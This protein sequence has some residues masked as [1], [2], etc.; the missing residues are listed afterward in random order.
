[1]VEKKKKIYRLLLSTLFGM[2]KTFGF[3]F[4][5]ISISKRFY[6]EVCGRV[7]KEIRIWI[8]HVKHQ[9]ITLTEKI[10]GHN[11]FLHP[12]TQTYHLIRLYQGYWC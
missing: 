11:M 6:R 12:G 1:M 3:F 8:K 7:E 2:I 5:V 4:I 10:G 9:L